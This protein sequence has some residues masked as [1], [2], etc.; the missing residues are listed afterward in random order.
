MEVETPSALMRAIKPNPPSDSWRKDKRRA[1]SWATGVLAAACVAGVCWTGTH[2]ISA[3]N[4]ND[5]QTIQIKALEE[6][7]QEDRSAIRESQKETSNKLDRIM[8]LIK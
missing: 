1:V 2:V 3:E 5:R 4:V 8:E 7:A 6:R